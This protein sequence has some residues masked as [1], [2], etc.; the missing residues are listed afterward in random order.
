MLINHV[1]GEECR[2]AIIEDG[3][4]EELYQERASAESHVGNI[5]K[6]RVVN[7]EP[8]IQ[9]AFIDFGLER[10]GFLHVTDLHPRYFPGKDR[11]ETELVGKKTPHRHRPPIQQS[12]K[13]GQE[14][15]VQVIKE[16]I[17]TKGPTLTSYLSIPGRF[18][19][20][21]P[22][23]ERLG[24]SRKVEDLDQRREMRALLD[25][26]D[27]PE[28]FGFIIRTAGHGKSKTDLKRD[29]SYLQR[30]WKAIDKRMNQRRVGELY[31][32]QDLVIR[33][34]RDVFA[35]DIERIIVDEP[36]AARRASDFLAI[37]SPRSRSS[38]LYYDDPVPLFDRFGVE[39][40]IDTI[41]SRTVPLPSGGSL[42]IDA[43]E[44]LVAVDVNSGKM[45]QHKNAE[46]TAYK[47]NQEACDEVC[48]QLRLRDLGGV[49]VIDL[50]DMRETKKRRSIEQQFRDN[51][52]KDRART[53]TLA[54]SQF[55]ILEMTRQRMRPSLKK[56]VYADCVKCGGAG[57]VKSVESTM[58]AAMR[59]IAHV[60]HRKNVARVEVRVSADVAFA[61]LNR[62]RNELVAV[63]QRN[64]VQV[65]VNVADDGQFDVIEVGAFDER[66]NVIALDQPGKLAQPQLQPV[67]DIEPV[68]ET[69]DEE[70]EIET[71]DE[72]KRDVKSDEQSKPESKDE[73]AGEEGG[74]KKRRRRRRRGGRGRKKDGD[75]ADEKSQDQAEE[76]VA[77]K[78][79]RKS[80]EKAEAK[81][82]EQAKGESKAD[83]QTQTD[84]RG[85]DGEAADG[86]APKK[87]R[88]RRRGGRR[89]RRKGGD[90]QGESQE[91]QADDGRQD[92]K[93]AGAKRDER[94]DDA[95]PARTEKDAA[96][97]K[98]DAGAKKGEPQD[99]GAKKDAGESKDTKDARDASAGKSDDG[100]GKTTKKK[101]TR[102][103]RSTKAAASKGDAK[104]DGAKAKPG[105][106]SKSNGE[107]GDDG[108]AKGDAGKAAAS[109]S[110]D[111][112]PPKKKPRRRRSKKKAAAETTDET[113][114]SSA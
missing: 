69:D 41:H 91:S 48:R 68:D 98:P 29:L 44:A 100:D 103:K 42:V 6:G 38:V 14:I 56:S 36:T 17:G 27:P 7:V 23:M 33:T 3:R 95:T 96:Q 49:V 93:Q 59:K 71:R 78:D 101:R 75:G 90:A 66:D 43:T 104:A 84:A 16:G 109:T 110:G 21:M 9:A 113:V 72:A 45:R 52:K 39:A 111:D 19:V 87:K 12:L 76:K 55:G 35:T 97:D 32:E 8:A 65:K 64:G 86:D 73:A 58:L 63:E 31:T 54:I 20:M 37:A 22:H 28:G 25:D 108:K 62:K 47:T 24:V 34:I 94:G 92:A 61:L 106:A 46:M 10:N 51:L 81:G 67:E 88:R 80:D 82:D 112:E 18:L 13:R 114:E 107:A 57:Q 83:E 50:I 102:R 53:K 105:D 4:L 89:R 15:L 11:E 30:L 79:E 85:D 70:D 77:A 5:Y 40:Q 26:L 2:I 99:A 60:A 1:P 74:K